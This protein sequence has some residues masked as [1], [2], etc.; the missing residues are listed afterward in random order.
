M[1]LRRRFVPFYALIFAAIVG[2]FLWQML[3]GICPVP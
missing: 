1:T 2:S 3:H